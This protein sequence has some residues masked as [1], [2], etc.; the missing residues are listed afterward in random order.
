[1]RTKPNLKAAPYFFNEKGF[2]LY[3][4]IFLGITNGES[5]CAQ[6]VFL[7]IFNTQHFR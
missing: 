4:V 2:Y 6:K 7:Y 3:D 5:E 1:M